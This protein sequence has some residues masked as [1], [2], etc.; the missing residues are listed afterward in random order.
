MV[1]HYRV[2][3]CVCAGGI[4]HLIHI[5][6][7]LITCYDVVLQDLDLARVKVESARRELVRLHNYRSQDDFFITFHPS[8]HND[9][10]IESLIN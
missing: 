4:R 7:F 6:V 10:Y 3:V 5:I 2:L 9:N 1:T 8:S